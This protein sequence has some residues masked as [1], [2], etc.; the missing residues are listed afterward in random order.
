MRHPEVGK[1]KSGRR[2]FVK[3][4]SVCCGAGI[5][6]GSLIPG[7]LPLNFAAGLNRLSDDPGEIADP[8][9]PFFKYVSNY[10]IGDYIPK[11]QGGKFI[12][13][14]L[15]GSEDDEKITKVVQEGLLERIYGTP[16]GW[17]KYEKSE[18]EKSVWLNR[19]YYLPPF[20]R[21]FYL[22]GDRKYLDYMMHIISQW[23]EDNPLLPDTPQRTYNWRDMQVAWRSIHLSWCYYLGFNGLSHD[24]KS[25]ILN[26]LRQHAAILLSGFGRQQLNEF[27]HQSH[28]ALAML[29]LGILFPDFQE[30]GDLKL[31]AITILDHHLKNAFYDDGG[32]KEQ[33]FGYYPFESH[34]FRDAYQL[35][36]SNNTAPAKNSLPMLK[37]MAAFMI[38]SAQPNGTMPPVNDSYEMPVNFAVAT[39]NELLGDDSVI[40]KQRSVYYPDT[41]IGI[42]RDSD[43]GKWYIMLYPAQVIGSHA[44]AGRLAVNLW[45]NGNPVLVDSGCCNYDDPALVSW[46]RT[47]RAHNTVLIDGKSDEATSSDMLWVPRRITANRITGWQEGDEIKY[48]RMESPAS[49]PANSGVKWTRSIGL[50]RHDFV[51]IYD[52]FESTGTH[53]YEVLFHFPSITAVSEKDRKLLINETIQIIPAIPDRVSDIILAQGKVSKE[54][55]NTP[56]PVVSYLLKGSGIVHSIFI[57][58]PR[59]AGYDKTRVSHKFRKDGILIKI[60]DSGETG[61]T[62]LLNSDSIKLYDAKKS[63]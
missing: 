40:A 51:L 59:R 34:I 7:V 5:S 2:K 30:A 21:L 32:N 63:K 8:V 18:I 11:D 6:L 53:N 28:G 15:I 25:K 10:N 48:C 50:I 54:G 20:A 17:D 38:N 44:H 62:L 3:Q 61:T 19:F 47:S 33:M 27:N 49:E 57:I 31:K 39:I 9:F 29:Y 60:K 56:A 1:M 58:L 22:T 14:Q 16:V 55:I 13:M 26:S 12:Q 41:Q 36:V 45:Y 35:C 52:K 24:E 37:K 46:Y 23:I 42:L 4:I 43:P